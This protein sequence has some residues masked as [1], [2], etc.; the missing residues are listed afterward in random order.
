MQYII[1]HFVSI[2]AS[3]WNPWKLLITVTRFSLLTFEELYSREWQ[4]RAAAA[5]WSL[6]VIVAGEIS[7]LESDFSTLIRFCGGWNRPCRPERLLVSKHTV[8]YVSAEW[9]RMIVAIY[10]IQ[11][12]VSRCMNDFLEGRTSWN[13]ATL[14]SMLLQPI[15]NKYHKSIIASI[16]LL[17]PE[18]K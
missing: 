8:V 1:M 17:L 6:E 11:C 18:N 3:E 10:R 15:F 16:I 7:D 4:Q 13:P 5:H 2:P 14:H 12:I 9:D